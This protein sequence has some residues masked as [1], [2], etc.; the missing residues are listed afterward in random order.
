MKVVVPSWNPQ[1]PAGVSESKSSS[2]TGEPTKR[3]ISV[4][5]TQLEPLT[6]P[7]PATNL[8]PLEQDPRK[9][10]AQH[11][12]FVAGT[13]A[14]DIAFEA[15]MQVPASSTGRSD[16]IA[17]NA[18]ALT[19]AICTGGTCKSFQKAQQIVWQALELGYPQVRLVQDLGYQGQHIV[20]FAAILAA[21][22]PETTNSF[23]SA[24]AQKATAQFL[25][26]CVEFSAF[27]RSRNRV[28]AVAW[29]QALTALLLVHFT[30]GRPAIIQPTNAVIQA[31][32]ASLKVVRKS[33]AAVSESKVAT[34]RTKH[35]L[36]QFANLLGRLHQQ[37]REPG[38]PVVTS[39]KAPLEQLIHEMRSA[40]PAMI[41]ESHERWI[42][43]IAR[44]S[45]AMVQRLNSKPTA[46]AAAPATLKYIFL[47]NQQFDLPHSI[48]LT[49]LDQRDKFVLRVPDTA[50]LKLKTK[51]QKTGETPSA[52]VAKA[53]E[54]IFEPTTILR[55]PRCVLLTTSISAQ[56]PLPATPNSQVCKPL[57]HAH[58]L[59]LF[60]RLH[61][62]A[63]PAQVTAR[64]VLEM[65]VQV[66]LY[67][68]AAAGLQLNE[69][70]EDAYRQQEQAAA[71][72]AAETVLLRASNDITNAKQVS[73]SIAKTSVVHAIL[74]QVLQV[75]PQW[76]DWCSAMAKVAAERKQRSA[77]QSAAR[78]NKRENPPLS[79]T[80]VDLLNS[81]CSLETFVSLV[82]AMCSDSLLQLV[83]H[84]WLAAQSEA[85]TAA[86]S[87]S[88]EAVPRNQ[89][90]TGSDASAIDDTTRIL[91]AQMKCL[92]CLYTRVRPDAAVT[93]NALPLDSCGA[94]GHRMLQ[95]CKRLRS[96]LV[97]A[98]IVQPNDY[99]HLQYSPQH[100]DADRQ[101]T[102][103][104]HSAAGQRLPAAAVQTSPLPDE[105]AP[106][107]RPPASLKRKNAQAASHE[108]PSKVAKASAPTRTA[109]TRRGTKDVAPVLSELQL[110]LQDLKELRAHKA[111]AKAAEGSTEDGP[112]T[113]KKRNSKAEASSNQDKKSATT[114]QASKSRLQLTSTK[115]WA[116]STSSLP[117]S[118]AAWQ[119]TMPE[120]LRATRMRVDAE[121]QRRFHAASATVEGTFDQLQQLKQW[122]MENKLP[123]LSSDFTELFSAGIKESAYGYR[124][125]NAYIEEARVY[126]G[127]FKNY[128]RL[129]IV[130]SDTLKTLAHLA[131]C[132][133]GQ[134]APLLDIVP[135]EVTTP[136]EQELLRAIA[137]SSAEV[138]EISQ[139]WQSCYSVVRRLV[140]TKPAG[141]NE[142]RVL[143]LV[144]L[145][146]FLHRKLSQRTQPGGDHSVGKEAEMPEPSWLNQHVPVFDAKQ[147]TPVVWRPRG[148]QLW[149]SAKAMKK[150]RQDTTAS[151]AAPQATMHP[152]AV[153]AYPRLGSQLAFVRMD[154]T[155]WARINCPDPK[156]TRV[157]KGSRNIVGALAITQC[158]AAGWLQ[159]AASK[160][161]A[162]YLGHEPQSAGTYLGSLLTNG[163]QTF[164]SIETWAT[165]SD[166]GD[167]IRAT[168]IAAATA[169]ASAAGSA[170]SAHDTTAS[171]HRF[172]VGSAAGGSAVGGSAGAAV[173][174]EV[175]SASGSVCPVPRHG[176]HAAQA[177][178]SIQDV[179]LLQ[180]IQSIGEHAQLL[181]DEKKD[182]ALVTNKKLMGSPGLALVDAH[183]SREAAVIPR[184]GIFN[185]EEAMDDDSVRMSLL[186]GD[187]VIAIDLGVHNIIAAS[188]LIC[189]SGQVMHRRISRK[190]WYKNLQHVEALTSSKTSRHIRMR[191]YCS[192]A[193]RGSHVLK[194]LGIN[195]SD[196][197]NVIIVAGA[198][199]VGQRRRG[200]TTLP[201]PVVT[202]LRLLSQFA[203]VIMC[204]EFHTSSSCSRPECLHTNYKEMVG[205]TGNKSCSK[206]GMSAHRD[207]NASNNIL[208]AALSLLVHGR[209]PQ[210]LR[211]TQPGFYEADPWPTACT[212]LSRCPTSALYRLAVS[213][214]LITPWSQV[215][216]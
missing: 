156:P 206:C 196:D 177:G 149:G 28:D 183:F 87:S 74:M 102:L 39:A 15:S 69:L 106:L 138:W 85:A 186:Q 171:A 162:C 47:T 144:A 169:P 72:H 67:T 190:D 160:H 195:G 174:A 13:Q 136:A 204:N 197:L 24:I 182:A 59:T 142:S 86:G 3:V 188:I 143:V 34:R 215:R 118:L 168:G 198:G 157:G 30:R 70:D 76:I 148:A 110:R 199:F 12:W 185:L 89:V 163:R 42:A 20:Q 58:T 117:D 79:M 170:G 93:K 4:L 41:A 201:S 26:A 150:L 38:K 153:S 122:A 66:Q 35:V 50:T 151:Q 207:Y 62:M 158:V 147:R 11:N 189:S 193:R 29:I 49:N 112:T 200:A 178:A 56:A 32:H 131:G 155:T 165:K 120:L 115:S 133:A 216:N 126:E 214:R 31:V 80:V 100:H 5:K 139:A 124:N 129:K 192:R 103:K 94:S 211:W 63:S 187:V 77:D 210:A 64:H 55:E 40:T 7:G 145:R 22:S 167:S 78:K 109:K 140:D 105:P 113:S 130:R 95:N 159:L 53:A 27:P 127:N 101:T 44:A 164:V 176:T 173:G 82:N 134:V 16:D 141:W 48:V 96:L 9:A 98:G 205:A 65:R 128:C 146:A 23:R 121:L 107:P 172:A 123:L 111:Q 33:C 88:S 202:I 125:W 37:I 99:V 8:F 90:T 73:D 14:E 194:T 19:A 61:M 17:A 184:T 83:P 84:W 81:A 43:A 132:P 52:P 108:K 68:M 209:V 104:P 137:N 2:T 18:G 36:V 1:T 75:A 116:I 154:L 166:A 119:A 152:P 175:T 51:K 57:S 208:A 191:R 114:D 212:A 180:R 46:S 91:V 135:A 181:D 6:L 45:A 203:P 25:S 10:E 54:F 161:C 21:L 71:V 60:R 97:H 213:H 92:V 179:S